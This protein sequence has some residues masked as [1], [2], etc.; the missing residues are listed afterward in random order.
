MKQPVTRPTKG[1]LVRA[2]KQLFILGASLM[3]CGTAMAQP[4]I[5]ADPDAPIDGGVSLLVAAGVGY[6]AKKIH[7]ARKKQKGQSSE[8]EIVIK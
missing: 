4:D 6:G 3:I 2:A 8:D 7:E 5:D 1:F